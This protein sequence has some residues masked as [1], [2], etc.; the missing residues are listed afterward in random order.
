MCISVEVRTISSD[1]VCFNLSHCNQNIH[2]HV[3]LEIVAIGQAVA[4]RVSVK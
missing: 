4:V 3:L 1:Y 2:V